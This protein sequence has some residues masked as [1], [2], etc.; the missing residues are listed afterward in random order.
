MTLIWKKICDNILAPSQLNGSQIVAMLTPAGRSPEL[1]RHAASVIFARVQLIAGIFAVL[2][3][4]CSVIDLLVFDTQTALRLVG[5]R[6]ASAGIFIALA[7]PREL[8]VTRGYGQALGAL[9][10]LLLVPP[11]FHVMSADMLSR[12]AN[13]HVQ[14]L[15]AQLYAYLPTIVLGGLAIFPLTALETLILALPVIGIGF[16]NT[17]LAEPMLTLAQYGGTL[18]FMC[19]MLGVAMFSGMSQCHY[20]ATLVFKAMHDPLTTAYTRQSGEEAINLLYRLNH[21]AAKPLTVAFIDL[22]RFKSINDNFGH[23]AGDQCLRA[24]AD[25]IRAALRRSDLLIRWGGE[26]FV[27]VLPDTPLDNVSTLLTRLRDS[28]LGERPDGTPLTAS[29]GIANSLEENVSGWETLI[30]R[31][32]Q[33]MYA[34]KEQGR[35]RAI[36]PDGTSLSLARDDEP[37]SSTDATT[38]KAG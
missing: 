34:A 33:R 4:L 21:M 12:A 26:E 15:V 23:E 6:F 22:D 27:A 1:R 19:M 28:G 38:S 2:V 37:T 36:W 11:L 10:I 8:S 24:L 29:I 17:L 35:N 31:A 13:T 5:M 25:T 9:L 20:M 3:P 18:W 32:D 14:Q 30:Q 16:G 7:W